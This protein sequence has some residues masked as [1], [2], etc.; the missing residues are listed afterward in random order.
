MIR[1]SGARNIPE[2]LRTVPGVNVAR[3]TGSQWA[4]TIR[5]FNGMYA[6]KLLVQ[7]DGRS[8]YTPLYSGV[9]WDQHDVLLEDVERIEVIRGPGAAVWGANAVNG[10][11][12]IITKKARDT[13]GAF[14]Q[15]GAGSEE[16]GFGAVRFGDVVGDS[17]YYRVHGKATERDGG[18]NPVDAEDDSRRGRFGFRMDW[19]PCEHTSLTLQGDY[20]Q[21]TSGQ[22]YDGPLSTPPF[23]QSGG[24]REEEYFGANILARLSRTYD[25][26]TDWSLRLYG[27]R[28]K[29][30]SDNGGYGDCADRFDLD[31]QHRFQLAPRHSLICGA[32]Y[33][34]SRTATESS[35]VVGFDPAVRTF[36]R[37]SY[38]VQ[39]RIEL[40]EDL[41]YLTLGSKFEHNDFSNFEYQPTAR[42]LW[43]PSQRQTIWASVSRAVRTPAISD[44]GILLTFAPV[45]MS[46]APPGATLMR[47]E[48][49]RAVESENVM[50]YEM[51]LR[52][53]PTDDLW[54][55]VA[56]FFNKYENLVARVPATPFPP[57]PTFPPAY[58]S[59]NMT[60]AM[61][62]ETYGFG[63]AATYEVNPCWRL[64]GGYSFLRMHLH[65]RDDAM[66]NAESGE[67]KSP[68]NQV[69]MQSGWDIGHGVELDLTGRYV[70]GLSALQIPGYMAMDARLAWQPRESLELAVVGRHL[71]DASHYEYIVP[72]FYPSE[73][74]SE[75]YA[76][77]TWRH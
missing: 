57:A 38:F 16:R 77:V 49:N 15:G 29:R 58:W 11:I 14:A 72:N 27:D 76:S 48:G 28:N 43:T 23:W 12:N 71:L 1:R 51:G 22:R 7:I 10:V 5:G 60:N 37:I 25:D 35:Y 20:E 66:A 8:I 56:V 54:W 52:S 73:V 44:Q 74:L 45:A 9:F 18:F 19:E 41:L 13:Q 62:G 64:S 67:G 65:A 31:F 42:L 70:D 47:T 68:Q 63:L 33:R 32:G 30:W 40:R 39:D 75:V 50:A 6:N 53:Q 3:I 69:Y 59:L 34:V 55:D 46:F 21:G 4:V 61:R 2:V 24:N 17:L 36:D 26:Q